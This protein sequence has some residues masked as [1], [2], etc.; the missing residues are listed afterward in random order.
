MDLDTIF[1]AYDVRGIYPDQLDEEAAHAI[2]RAF[3][4]FA[5]ARRIG[6]GRDMRDSSE[7][8]STAFIAGAVTQGADVADLGMISTDLLYYASGSLGIPGAMFTASH[9][10]AEYNGIKMCL[11][12]AAPVGQDT[13]LRQIKEQASR[14]SFPTSKRLGTIQRV[15][16]LGAYIDHVLAQADLGDARPLTVAA[17]AANGMGGLIAPALFERLPFKLVPLYFEL[18]GTFPNHPA[19]PLQPEN[20]A[21]LKAAVL[22]HRADIGIAFDGDADRAFFLDERGDPVSGS[23]TAAVVARSIL[24]RYPGE[25]VIHNVICSRV[26]PETIRESG[27][28]PVRSRVGHSFIKELMAKT[29]AVFG[30][31]HSGHY[32]FRENYRADSGLIAA[33]HMLAV[34]GASEVPLSELLAPFN[35]YWNSGE[36]NT[37][38]ADQPA[39]IEAVAAA[40]PDGTHDL[41]DGLTVDWEDRWFNVRPSNTEPL[42]RLNV[43]AGSPADGEALRDRVLAI[44]R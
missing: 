22:D 2:G 38:V 40:F 43:E 8:L 24:S 42:L 28:E 41:I 26:V 19:D 10:P 32:Y 21:D 15:D 44:I 34:L 36:I 18:D 1:K 9:N 16:L 4:D 27:G 6:V 14:R 33:V 20:L 17:D 31:E 5:D 7:P 3:V 29:G 25:K 13:G 35:R 37:T 11:A 30:A 12:G 39:A 23:L